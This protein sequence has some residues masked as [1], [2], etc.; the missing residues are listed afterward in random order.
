MNTNVINFHHATGVAPPSQHPI[1]VRGILSWS[2][3]LHEHSTELCDL[4]MDERLPLWARNRISQQVRVSDDVQD[5][6]I[7]GLV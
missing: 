2:D 1:V 6:M 4:A 7:R 3:S 5:D